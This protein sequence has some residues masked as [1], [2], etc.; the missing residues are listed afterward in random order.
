MNALLRGL[1]NL[2]PEASTYAGGV[3]LLHFFVIASTMLGAAFIFTLALYFGIRYRRRVEGETT[4]RV[5]TSAPMEVA[6]IGS[7][8][9]LFLAFWVIGALQY[10][11]IFTPPPG[12]TPVYVTGK[13][14]MWTFS[15]ADGRASMDVLTVPVHRPIKLVMTSRDV[16]H[17]FYVP[18]FRMKHD[19]VP[20]RYYTAWFEATKPGVYDIDCAEYC[21]VNHSRMLGKV[22]VLDAA[23]YAQWLESTTPGPDL[24]LVTRGRDVALRRGCLNCHTLDGQKHI[25]PSW[26]GL[27]HSTVRTQD[28]RVVY[29]DEA[30]LTRSM[31]DPLADV[32][33]GYKAVMPTYRGVLEQPEVAALLELMKSIQS[34]PIVAG[35]TLPPVEPLGSAQP[36]E[37]KP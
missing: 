25:G 21:G 36:Q 32:V 34:V 29:A 12:A 2:P 18:A 20:G 26:A 19:V 17:S 22:R 11:H 6:I 30:Y 13:Q 8:L 9:T 27:Y 1:L 10:N 23:D 14:W 5:G 35:I 37:P 7:L 4:A 15:Y 16:I 28:G 3:D 33:S 24:D 31:M